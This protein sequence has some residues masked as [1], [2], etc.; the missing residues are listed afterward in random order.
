MKLNLTRLVVKKNFGYKLLTSVLIF[1][2][3]RGKVITMFFKL[4]VTN[5]FGFLACIIF[6]WFL[7]GLK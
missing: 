6:G 5:V 4:T 1:T 7:Q 2:K 3:K